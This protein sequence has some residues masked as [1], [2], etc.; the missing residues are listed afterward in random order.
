VKETPI[1]TLNDP[2]GRVIAF[3]N[4]IPSYRAGLATIDL[5]R[6]RVEIPNGTMD[7]LFLKL[8]TALHAEGFGAFS[9]G[10]AALAG[11][12]DEPGASLQE[13]AM[14]EIFNHLNRFFAFKGLRNYKAKFDPEWEDRFLVYQ[15]GPVGLVRT[16]F[17]FARATEG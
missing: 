8:L 4:E 1:F 11:V 15:G 5:M 12:G 2:A 17:A 13:R 9:L 10:M 3:A 14:H 6:H 16:G 7:Y